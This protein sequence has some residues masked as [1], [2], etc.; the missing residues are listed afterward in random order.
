[1]RRIKLFYQFKIAIDRCFKIRVDKHSY[2]K[3]NCKKE[4]IFSY[5]YRR[6]IIAKTDQFCKFIERNYQEIKMIKE[7]K[8]YHVQQFLEYKAKTCTEETLKSYY[9]YFKK[10]ERM[11]RQE[12][13]LNVNFTDGVVVNSAK[14]S[15]R[16]ISMENKDLEILNKSIEDSSSKAVIGIKIAELFGLRACEICKLQGRDI[17]LVNKKLHIHESKGKRS[18]DLPIDSES[19]YLLCKEIK[20]SVTDFE[21]VV[22]LREDSLNAF[23]RRKL[24][25]NNITR[26]NNSCTGIHSIRKLYAKETYKDELAKGVTEKEAVNYV[27]NSLGH[28]D[29]RKITVTAYINSK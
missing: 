15:R 21:R 28:G 6:N 26:Y 20:E 1:M 4:K 7:I 3:A 2:K 17:D 25:S 24:I 11:I 14:S 12:M 18:R 23:L 22:P 13:Y 19:K 8:S 29:G 27:S 10:M 16:T 5:S 9:Y